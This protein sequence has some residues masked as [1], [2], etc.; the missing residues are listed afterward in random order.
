M[1]RC[2][3]WRRAVVAPSLLL[4]SLLGS[5]LPVED[6]ESVFE[7]VAEL[8][9]NVR[10]DEAAAVLRVALD[11]H[12]GTEEVEMRVRLT[13]E[14]GEVLLRQGLHS[15][16]T[17]SDDLEH[18]LERSL[19]EALASEKA[20]LIG[21]T[22]RILASYHYRRELAADRLFSSASAH[23][24][25]ARLAFQE[26]GNAFGQARAIH[27][28]GLI[29][30]QR[31]D[32]ERARDLFDEAMALYRT[33]R[34]DPEFEADIQRHSGFVDLVGGSPASAVEHFRRSLE[35]RRKAGLRDG[36]MFALITLGSALLD[37]GNE[38]EASELLREADREASQIGS[39]VGM[40]RTAFYLGQLQE[41]RGQG[42][43]AR[44]EFERSLAHSRSIDY[45]TFIAHATTA[46]DAVDCVGP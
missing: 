17:A 16:T 3:E 14:L 6:V 32:L 42:C 35:L 4:V 30:F 38:T 5:A 24:Q 34:V 27:R 1:T 12:Q 40:A 15:N 41:R 43:A 44:E 8:R 28:Q 13:V 2:F 36:V 11:D 10:L 31:R 29:A 45:R 23:A 25:A 33:T 9:L 18:L 20:N 19:E 26:T 21:E 46:L 22:H 7:R 37:Q 39:K